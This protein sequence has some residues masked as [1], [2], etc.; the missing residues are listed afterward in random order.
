MWRT[1]WHFPSRT[2]LEGIIGCLRHSGPHEEWGNIIYPSHPLP[3]CSFLLLNVMCGL[4]QG[5]SA[6][7]SSIFIAAYGFSCGITGNLVWAHSGSPTSWYLPSYRKQL[8]TDLGRYWGFD[9]PSKHC[10]SNVFNN[11]HT[12]KFSHIHF[13][14]ALTDLGSSTHFPNVLEPSLHNNYLMNF[15][16]EL[17]SFLCV[18]PVSCTIPSHKGGSMN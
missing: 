1:L 8:L 18:S 5:G 7:Q 10:F 13:F 15:L 14:N 16:R 3:L 9:G 4:A 17:L 12:V 2:C 11:L 6:Q